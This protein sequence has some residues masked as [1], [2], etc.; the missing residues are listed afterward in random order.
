MTKRRAILDRM[1]KLSEAL[2]KA[3]EYLASGAHGHWTGF[4]PLIGG[5]CGRLPHRVW[6]ANVFIPR[7]VRAL[8]RCEIALEKVKGRAKDRR[9]NERRR[10]S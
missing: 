9:I 6:I 1:K 3:N 4:R 10:G 2:T 8:R 5:S 7:R